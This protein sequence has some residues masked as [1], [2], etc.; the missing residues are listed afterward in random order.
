M[1][2]LSRDET[3][4]YWQE[5][6][7]T[8]DPWRAGGHRGLD[9]KTNQLFYHVRFGLLLRM[10]A[11]HLGY[12]PGQRV[13]DAGCG[14][15]WLTGQLRALGYDAVGVDQ[16]IAA[17]EHATQTYDAPFHVAALDYFDP[18]QVFDAVV[19]MD[20]LYHI[21]EDRQWEQSLRNLGRLV[22]AQGVLIFSDSLEE[23]AKEVG[24][25]IVH[26]SRGQCERV[27]SKAAFT[28]AASEPYNVLGHTTSWYLCVRRPAVS[29]F[30]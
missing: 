12:R 5:R 30:R 4:A 29:G 23:E 28:I 17:V 9:E 8:S 14:R 3:A 1:A 19:A 6:H 20:V 7:R 10:L 15:G 25:Y 11:N 26:R 21:T 22:G 27:L 16:S 2:R 18:G 13:L 24:D